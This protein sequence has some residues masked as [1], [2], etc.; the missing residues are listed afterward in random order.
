V[1]ERGGAPGGG[2]AALQR[3]RGG[4][5][6]SCGVPAGA[7]APEE[8]DER[9][10]GECLADGAALAGGGDGGGAAVPGRGA[11]TRSGGCVCDVLGA[12]SGELRCDRDGEYVRGHLDGRGGDVGRV[13]GDDALGELGK[14]AEGW[15]GDRAL[16]A[17]PWEC[18]GHCGAG[19]GESARDDLERGDDAAALVGAGG[20]GEGGGGG[21]GCGHPG[22]APDARHRGARDEGGGH[23]D[24][25]ERG[26]GADSMTGWLGMA[27]VRAGART[28]V[29]G[30]GGG[31]RW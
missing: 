25:G 2:H 28:G 20:G 7:P 13:D 9:G 29:R 3:A 24:D 23:A 1:G 12:A 30:T 15:D 27:G 14:A 11:G 31:R 4:S 22:G 19:E 5:G 6:V 21:G 10:Q 16:R 26:S 17:D 18:A 8:G